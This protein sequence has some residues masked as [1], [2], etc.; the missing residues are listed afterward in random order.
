MKK[1][2]K[3]IIF[4]IMIVYVS[5]MYCTK[6]HSADNNLYNLPPCPDS[7]NCVSS[8]N[9]DNRHYIRPIA[10]SGTAEGAL[11]V[12]KAVITGLPRTAVMTQKPPYLHVTFTSAIFRFV[13]DVEFLIDSENEIIHVRSASRVGYW[14]FGV[15][16]SRVEKIRKLFIKMQERSAE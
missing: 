3:Y 4:N 11:K 15:N 5:V 13:D 14:D 1:F 9:S 8:L 2:Q 16:R 10:Y 7:P 12:L 6:I